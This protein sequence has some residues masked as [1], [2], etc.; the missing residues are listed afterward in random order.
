[1]QHTFE[2][3]E[4]KSRK[5]IHAK[6]VSCHS[7]PA[8]QGANASPWADMHLV[9]INPQG[10]YMDGQT[11]EWGITPTNPVQPVVD[12]I[13]TVHDKGRGV[14]GMKIYGNGDFTNAEDRE[15]S[16]QFALANPNIDALVIGHK[17]PAEID[18]TLERVNRILAAG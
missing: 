5:W 11:A 16:L 17:T 6:G 8:L 4:A 15:K 14:I 7:F 2:Y 1:M 13:K 10:K 9:R 18:E 3:D 12:L